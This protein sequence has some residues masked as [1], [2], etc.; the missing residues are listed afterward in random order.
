MELFL[1][2]QADFAKHHASKLV[3]Q[4]KAEPD[5]ELNQES[6]TYFFT[7]LRTVR[8]TLEAFVVFVVAFEVL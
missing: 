2:S 6:R 1:E 4:E 8:P 3:G 5:F 7:H